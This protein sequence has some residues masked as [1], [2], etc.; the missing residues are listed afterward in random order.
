[1][2]WPSGQSRQLR[3]NIKS[4]LYKKGEAPYNNILTTRMQPGS[5]PSTPPQPP[6]N[7]SPLGPPGAPGVDNQEDVDGTPVRPDAPPLGGT[8]PHGKQHRGNG[9]QG[10]VQPPFNPTGTGLFANTPPSFIGEFLYGS[11]DWSV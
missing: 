3:V 6:Q 7:G 11:G 10:V 9:S 1:M 4:R 2:D 5:P 8:P